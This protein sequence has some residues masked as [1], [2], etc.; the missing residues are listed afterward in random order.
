MAAVQ[1]TKQ[2]FGH[3]DI[4][5]I[6][7]TDNGPQYTSDLF[8]VFTQ[9]Y[10][11]H[12]VTSSP[13]WA[14]TNGRAEVAVKSAKRILLTADDV[15]LALLSV[16]NTPPTEHT[17]S[18]AQHLFGRVLRSDLPQMAGAVEPASPPRDTA[19]QEHITRKLQQKQAYKKWAGFPL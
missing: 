14:Q 9:K 10:K 19:V 3:H 1:V 5:H 2:H 15:D 6:F 11:F 4:P 12:P 17:Y 8:K 7:I 13:Y 18:P 16:C